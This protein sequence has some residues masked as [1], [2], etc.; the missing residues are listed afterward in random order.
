MKFNIREILTKYKTVAIVGL[1]KDPSKD[2]YKVA[3]YLK[4][5]GFFIIPINPSADKIL[6][7][8]SYK[9]LLDLPRDVQKSLEIVDI[10]RPSHE[11]LPIVEQ[12][13]KLKNAIG[14]PY[15]VWMQLGIVNNEA[16]LKAEKAGLTIVMDK[17]IM[18]EHRRLSAV[19]NL[20]ETNKSNINDKQNNQK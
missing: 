5:N 2:S 20:N 1:S 14:K 9:S 17:C 7:Q 6:G 12:A 19:N 11:V 13:I 4:N 15:V 16:A 8:K 3:K 18:Q 10:F